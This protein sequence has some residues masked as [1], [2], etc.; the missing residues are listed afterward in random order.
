MEIILENI[1]RRFNQEWIFRS[2]NYRF[3]R[4]QAYAILGA[5]GS[6][7]STLLQ[8][9]AGI[10]SASEGSLTYQ[11]GETKIES[12]RKTIQFIDERL[13]YITQELYDVEKEVEGYKRDKSLAFGIGGRATAY[14]ELL[15]SLEDEQLNDL[16]L[17]QALLDDVEKSLQDALSRNERLPTGTE[18]LGK[19][20]LSELI[21]TY[22]D[23]LLKRK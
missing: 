13:Q 17:Q 22:N 7:K 10:L 4:G 11:S 6:V 15:S 18:I 12:D 20:G 2:L 16:S 14:P 8:V 23:W 9:L 21:T 19:G 3:E 5:N 1:G